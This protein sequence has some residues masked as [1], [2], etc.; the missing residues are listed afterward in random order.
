MQRNATSSPAYGSGSRAAIAT[1]NIRV[2]AYRCRARSVTSSAI[3]C[4]ESKVARLPS[5]AASVGSAIATSRANATTIASQSRRATRRTIAAY[6]RNR[7]AS[8]AAPAA[9]TAVRS[10]DYDISSAARVSGNA[11]RA[12]AAAGK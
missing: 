12:A 6:K 1:N 3:A 9:C 2:T 10:E 4:I 8:T 7:S 5:T 11:S